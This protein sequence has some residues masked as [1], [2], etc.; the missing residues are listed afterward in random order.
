[1]VHHT[2]HVIFYPRYW[3]LHPSNCSGYWWTLNMYHHIHAA[4]HE[5]TCCKERQKL[6][7]SPALRLLGCEM[8]TFLLR[9]GPG[10]KENGRLM[11]TN[12]FPRKIGH[13]KKILVLN[14]TIHFQ[15]LLLLVSGRVIY[16]WNLTCMNRL[17]NKRGCLINCVSFFP[18]VGVHVSAPSMPSNNVLALGLGTVNRTAVILQSSASVHSPFQ[19]YELI[20]TFMK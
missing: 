8:I 13:P 17:E 19:M 15:V 14:P 11:I 4:P 16:Y 2:F 20:P 7:G 6:V 3:W 18:E 10:R 5:Q 12:I 9:S 1:M